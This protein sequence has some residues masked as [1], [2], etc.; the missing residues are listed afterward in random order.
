MKHTTISSIILFLLCWWLWPATI[1]NAQKSENDLAEMILLNLRSVENPL[2]VIPCA[3]ANYS[4]YLTT[5]ITVGDAVDAPLRYFT[6]SP[7]PGAYV[8]YSR[9]ATIASR[10]RAM[11]LNIMTGKSSTISTAYVYLFADWNRDGSFESSLGKHT[12]TGINSS[13]T[14]GVSASIE[15]PETA[16]LGKTRIRAILTTL[17]ATSINPNASVSSGYIHD[18]VLFIEEPT[19]DQGMIMINSSP[20]NPSWGTTLIESEAIPVDGRYPKNSIVTFKALKSGISEFV[21]W[22]DGKTIVSSELEY[23]ITASAPMYLIGIFKTPT[24]TLSAPEASSAENPVWFQIKNAQTDT[25]LD[26]FLAYS[27]TIPAGYTTALRIEKPENFSDTFLW[28]LDPADNGMVKLVNKGTGM[29]IAADGTLNQTLFVQP[30]G[31]T[32]KIDPSGHANGSYSIKLNGNA[33]QLLNGGLSFNVVLFNA[34][35]G[36]G[37]GWYFYKV[38]EITSSNRPTRTADIQTYI[39]NNEIHITGAQIGS[40]ATIYSLHG[41]A[42]QQFVISSAKQSQPFHL[43]GTYILLIENANKTHHTIKLMN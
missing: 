1:V 26:R 10:G 34:G 22:S 15:I 38:P 24:A 2:Y 7:P 16:R 37:S 23:E 36:T 42:V 21:G 18:F 5:A 25:R 43:Q 35:V 12:I 6:V 13:E 39:N 17:N 14:P 27:T 41:H 8:N 31:S 32:F 40:K 19:D 9:T 33:T 29:Q 20:N 4:L 30:G 3:T 11:E 28:R